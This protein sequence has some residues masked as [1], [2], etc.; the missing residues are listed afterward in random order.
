MEAEYKAMFSEAQEFLSKKVIKE[1]RT[2]CQGL[3]GDSEEHDLLT[4]AK[5]EGYRTIIYA[6]GK[7]AATDYSGVTLYVKTSSGEDLSPEGNGW[8][9]ECFGSL[10]RPAKLWLVIP[11]GQDI[12]IRYRSGSEVALKARIEILYVKE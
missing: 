1:V 12:K 7:D 6:I 3:T 8:N 11:R 4:I 10:E 9:M 5:R 2:I